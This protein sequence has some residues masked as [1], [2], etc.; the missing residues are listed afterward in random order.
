MKVRYN[1]QPG[2]ERTI[3]KEDFASHDITHDDVTFN[4]DNDHTA[5]LSKEVLD[6]LKDQGEP[7]EEV[8]AKKQA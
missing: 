1:A 8:K 2:Y 6:F 7:V 5:E 4:D 3:T